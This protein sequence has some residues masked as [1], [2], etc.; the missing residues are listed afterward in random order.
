MGAHCFG[1]RNERGEKLVQFSREKQLFFANTLFK[2]KN[3]RRATWLSPDGK[4]TNE[5]D[6]ILIKNDQKKLIKDYNAITNFHF[7][8][9]HKMVRME[10]YLDRTNKKIHTIKKR[11]VITDDEMKIKQFQNDMK[12][13]NDYDEL[14]STE[15]TYQQVIKCIKSA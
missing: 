13:L 2:K 6:F 9:D 11:I 8:S 7:N 15:E 3:K 5:V 4:T 1:V 12:N 14:K 10:I